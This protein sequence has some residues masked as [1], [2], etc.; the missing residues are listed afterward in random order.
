VRFSRGAYVC[1]ARRSAFFLPWMSCFCLIVFPV[2]I[3]CSGAPH[4]NQ[5]RAGRF[6]TR[7]SPSPL[8]PRTSS[9]FPLSSALVLP[10]RST[11]E[12]NSLIFTLQRDS[13]FFDTGFCLGDRFFL[14]R[15]LLGG[16]FITREHS[17]LSVAPS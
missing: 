5:R 16:I 4:L 12:P 15:S 2:I 10:A 6:R 7:F 14:R 8:W 1:P 13:L 11:F 9:F 17:S 3:P